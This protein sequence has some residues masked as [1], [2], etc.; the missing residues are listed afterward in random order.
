[1]FFG[2][3]ERNW[4][5]TCSSPASSVA[6]ST[7]RAVMTLSRTQEEFTRALDGSR[8]MQKAG[9]HRDLRAMSGLPVTIRL[10]DPPIHEFISMPDF[11]QALEEAE[12]QEIPTRLERARL[13]LAVAREL[14]ETNPMLGT[15]GARLGLL[16]PPLYEMQV[17]GDPGGCPGRCCYGGNAEGRDHD[18]A[19]RLRERARGSC[20]I[21]S[22]SGPSGSCT[23]PGPR[24][25]TRSAR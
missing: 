11:E 23:M 3:D 19:D 24:L 9:L 1:M 21:W 5:E 25:S 13:R 4:S 15:R 18:P 10:L 2:S 20:G 7:S 14:E 6:V 22:I 12:R 8:K 16:L 17:A